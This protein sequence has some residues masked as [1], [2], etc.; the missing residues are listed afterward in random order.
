V[1]VLDEPS[2]ALDANA[3]RTLWKC[4][5]MNAKGRAIVLTTHSMEEADALADRIG[6]V[7]SR[8][9][10]S[11]DRDDMKRRAGNQ[12]HIH[13]VSA[14]APRTTP[15]E[16]QA[17]RDWIASEFADDAEI[18]R[19]TQGGQIRFQVPAQGR[20]LV[21]L[22]RVLEEKKGQLGV[23]YY[24]VGQATLDEV[25]ENIVKRYGDEDVVERFQ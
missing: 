15:A 13:L 17:M 22:I 1:L 6:I 7:S 21:E 25:F 11:G 19:E 24:S 12:F 9:L 23:E 4:L 16:L 8:M 20:S 10:A 5:Q 3:K 2:S 18:S 14:S